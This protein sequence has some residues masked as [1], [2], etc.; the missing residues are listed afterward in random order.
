LLDGTLNNSSDTAFEAFDSTA[1]KA[2][3][4]VGAP[5]AACPSGDAAA[6]WDAPSQLV[7]FRVTSSDPEGVWV[8]A[9]GH[10]CIPF[11]IDQQVGTGWQRL[12]TE[13]YFH[14]TDSC[15]APAVQCDPTEGCPTRMRRATATTAV[16]LQWSGYSLSPSG[17]QFFCFGQ[18]RPEM[19]RVA[20]PP[21]GHYRVTVAYYPITKYASTSSE[22][23][24]VCDSGFDYPPPGALPLCSGEI[25]GKKHFQ[26]PMTKA[27]EFD[28]PAT[29]PLDVPIQVP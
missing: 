11:A 20:V 27:I 16:G 18:C 19:R 7:T 24:N 9:Q 5:K 3:S 4:D 17:T 8:V 12:A 14:P 15:C 21:G 13:V 22:V 1:L 2:D 25:T 28:L 6:G 29:G 10:M 23:T 26:D